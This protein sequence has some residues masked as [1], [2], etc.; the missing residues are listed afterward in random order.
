MFNFKKISIAMAAVLVTSVCSNSVVLAYENKLNLEGVINKKVDIVEGITGTN[1]IADSISYGSKFH[2]ENKDVKSE[3]LI[4]KTINEPISIIDKEDESLNLKI[5]L[6]KDNNIDAVS[7][8]DTGTILYY[9]KNYA[10]VDYSVQPTKDGVKSLITINDSSASKEYKFNLDLPEGSKLVTSADYLGSEYDTGEVYIVDDSNIITSIFAPAWAK[11]AN[12]NSVKT[13]YKVEGNNLIQVVE[14]NEN[15]AFPIVADPNWSKVSKCA[16]AVTWAVGSGL[17]V[18]AKLIKIKKY[19][20]A[21]GGFRNTAILLTTCTSYQEKL[22]AG[23]KALLGL[24]AQIIG[25]D[26]IAQHCF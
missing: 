2:S 16:S 23:G 22:E 25:V 7:K 14:F 24:S 18:G 3:L 17:F 1:D 12:N 9:N 8:S 11:D 26:K 5:H 6:P 4:P 13:Y 20:A 15:S 10:P 21:L 19:I